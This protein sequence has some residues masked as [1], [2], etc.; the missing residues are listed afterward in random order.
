VAGHLVIEVARYGQGR[1]EAGATIRP[2]VLRSS[3]A[4]G[5]AVEPGASGR[6]AQTENELRLVRL[7]ARSQFDLARA[8]AHGVEGARPDVVG[9]GS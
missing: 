3:D 6:T 2:V 1:R 8:V 5:P 9:D 4:E 7:H